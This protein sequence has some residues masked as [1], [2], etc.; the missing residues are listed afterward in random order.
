MLR[1]A[2]HLLRQ[3]LDALRVELSAGTPIVVLEP[4]CASV[5]RDELLNLF[6]N[7][8]DA[9]RLAAQTL[10]LGEFLERYAP[11]F[12][13]P[14]LSLAVGERTLLPAVRAAPKDALIVADGFSCREQIAQ[15]TDRRALHLAE[16][17]QLAL[18]RGTS[19]ATGDTRGDYPER[20]VTPPPASPAR[21]VALG[22]V[23]AAGALLG[24]AALARRRARRG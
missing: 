11:D 15:T 9:K 2:K 13:P 21:A 20:A 23:A 24:L 16:V 14:R 7:D 6:P 22:T 3:T 19:P 18:R 1:T 5:F 4:S 10:L 17:L 8:E 12:A